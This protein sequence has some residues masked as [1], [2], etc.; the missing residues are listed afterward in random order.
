[1]EGNIF[2]RE[3][4]G[5]LLLTMEDGSQEEYD[6]PEFQGIHFE[7]I[8]LSPFESSTIAFPLGQQKAILE[9]IE[10]LFPKEY[11]GDIK[12]VSGFPHMFI[13]EVRLYADDILLNRQDGTGYIIHN[14]INGKLSKDRVYVPLPPL[15]LEVATNLILEIRLTATN[16]WLKY[17]EAQIPKRLEKLEKFVHRDVAQMIQLYDD[18]LP[19]KNKLPVRLIYRFP[20]DELAQKMEQKESLRIQQPHL[21]LKQTTLLESLAN[22]KTL[23][24]FRGMYSIPHLVLSLHFKDTPLPMRVDSPD[25]NPLMKV[26][27]FPIDIY[28]ESRPVRGDLIYEKSGREL[29][30]RRIENSQYYAQYTFS[31]WKEVLPAQLQ[32]IY[33]HLVLELRA[34][35]DLDCRV[36]SI[37]M[38]EYFWEDDELLAQ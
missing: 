9:A 13:E 30:M 32:C 26:S 6:C 5:T 18:P 4:Y 19:H 1:M 8:E 28:D 15:P 20:N 22:R 11:W 7:D 3:P 16:E 36:Y 24:L 14:M 29:Q 38:K 34:P 12:H 33:F 27:I 25:D 17:L 23:L 37:G 10:I 35:L 2:K 31:L 21:Q